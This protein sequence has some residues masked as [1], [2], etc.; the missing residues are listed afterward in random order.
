[1]ERTIYVASYRTAPE[2]GAVKGTWKFPYCGTDRSESAAENAERFEELLKDEGKVP[3]GCAIRL[4]P[5][6]YYLWDDSGGDGRENACLRGRK[7]QHTCDMRI[8]TS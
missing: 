3:E 7:I 2:E 1:M 5:G 6:V 4:L 8:I